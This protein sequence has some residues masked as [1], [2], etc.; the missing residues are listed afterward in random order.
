MLVKL[1]GRVNKL[2]ENF[3]KELENVKME[4]GKHKKE[5]ARNEECNN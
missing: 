5:P 3:N 4:N 2:S 1:R